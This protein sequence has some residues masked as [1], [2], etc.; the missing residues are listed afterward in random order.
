MHLQGASGALSGYLETRWQMSLKDS[1]SETSIPWQP[2]LLALHSSTLCFS[3]YPVSFLPTVTS[4]L[5]PS[6]LFAVMMCCRPFVLTPAW[7][8]RAVK[9]LLDNKAQQEKTE[10]AYRRHFS[11]PIHNL[12]QHQT[13]FS[14]KEEMAF[15]FPHPNTGYLFILKSHGIGFV[16][17]K[18]NSVHLRLHALNLCKQTATPLRHERFRRSSRDTVGPRSGASYAANRHFKPARKTRSKIDGFDWEY[19]PLTPNWLLT[20]SLKREMESLSAIKRLPDTNCPLLSVA[21]FLL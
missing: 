21:L 4:L 6:V 1:C 20:R 13:A 7:R 19:S 16:D 10:T 2:L 17:R 12:I 5:Q 11:M 8:R 3:L 15:F 14:A 18:T 9:R